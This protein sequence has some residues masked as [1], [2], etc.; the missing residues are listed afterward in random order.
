MGWQDKALQKRRM[1]KQIKEIMNSPEYKQ[2]EREREDQMF[3]SALYQ[4][5]FI[6]CEFL[7]RNHGYKKKGLQKFLK[8]LHDCIVEADD[9][10][11]LSQ[12]KY[13]KEEMN[14]DVLEV[15]GMKIEG[16]DIED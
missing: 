5:S 14:L 16:D 8:Y 6:S 15:F 3:W 9:G 1:E 10:F 13:Y 2:V 7:E 12:D 4:L 11:Y